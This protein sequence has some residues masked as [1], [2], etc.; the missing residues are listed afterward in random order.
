VPTNTTRTGPGHDP[1]DASGQVRT[2]GRAAS[3]VQSPS[4]SVAIR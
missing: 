4:E 2:A 1:W 3:V